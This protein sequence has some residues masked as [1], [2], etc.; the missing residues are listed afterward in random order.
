M[1]HESDFLRDLDRMRHGIVLIVGSG[2]TYKTGTYVQF[3]EHCP[4]LRR[5]RKSFVGM[6]DVS[7]IPAELNAH[8]CASMFD[9]AVGDNGIM[10]DLAIWF[11]SRDKNIGL[12]RVMGTISHQDKLIFGTCQNT[13]NV[14]LA[15]FRDQRCIIIHKWMDPHGIVFE[16]SDLQTYQ[17]IANRKIKEASKRYGLHPIFFSYIPDYSELLCMP[18][19][20]AWYDERHSHAL[21][22]VRFTSKGEVV[23]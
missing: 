10:D 19:V 8:P 16:R 21:R 1:M 17:N 4:T 6:S 11:P 5:R 15:L 22:Y 18:A 13:S 23:A 2:K 14:D 12:Q 7:H 9:I 20:P 3:Y